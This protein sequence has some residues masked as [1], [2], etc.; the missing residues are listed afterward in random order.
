MSSTNANKY[1]CQY[2]NKKK[3]KIPD[4][5]SPDV[6]LM[7]LDVLNTEHN[8]KLLEN[9]YTSF[10]GDDKITLSE[11]EV[12]SNLKLIIEHNLKNHVYGRIFKS[13][14]GVGVVAIRNIPAGVTLFDSTLGACVNYHPIGFSEQE[15][16]NIFGDS[17]TESGETVLQYLKDFYLSQEG[18]QIRLPVNILGPNMMDVSFFLNHSDNANVD[19]GFTDECD[20]SVYKSNR[21]IKKGEELTINY[22]HFSIKKGVLYEFMPFLKPAQV[23]NEPMNTT[24]GKKKPKRKTKK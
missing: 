13:E 19:M 17:N 21:L 24:G 23:S 3:S 9:N 11:K 15:I 8:K 14:Y 18:N 4:F 5:Y 22:N 6:P 16:L 7:M 2:S 10:S 12:K 1:V 20:M